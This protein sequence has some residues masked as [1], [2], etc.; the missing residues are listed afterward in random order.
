MQ[1]IYRMIVRLDNLFNGDKAL[2]AHMNQF[3]NE[4]WMDVWQ[5]L[6]PSVQATIA[7][8]LKNVVDNIFKTFA[9]EDIYLS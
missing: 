1:F 7:E 2:G 9:Y 3:L 4:N 5:E 8:I 6:Q